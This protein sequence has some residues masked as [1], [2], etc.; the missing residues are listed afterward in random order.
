[1]AGVMGSPHALLLGRQ[2]YDQWTGDH[3]NCL[4]TG[5][6][7]KDGIAERV[8]DAVSEVTELP[9]DA[10]WVVFEEVEAEGW[11]IGHRSVRAIR[12]GGTT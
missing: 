8:V 2:L 9:T 1:M 10:I 3:N 7:R 5:R 12:A 11:Y 6:A 4:L